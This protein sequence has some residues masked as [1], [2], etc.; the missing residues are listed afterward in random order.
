MLSPGLE[1]AD[2]SALIVSQVSPPELDLLNPKQHMLPRWQ[3]NFDGAVC[4][5]EPS[6]NLVS[7]VTVDQDSAPDGQ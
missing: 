3:G 6:A 2:D 1:V 4:D 7:I 5:P